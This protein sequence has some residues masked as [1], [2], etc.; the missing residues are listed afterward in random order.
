[1]ETSVLALSMVTP[2]LLL[3]WYFHSRDAYPE[4]GRV[5]WTTFGL[6]VFTV[7]PVLAF[8]MP[9]GDALGSFTDPYAAGAFEAF[10]LASIPEETCKLAVLLLYARRHSAF[11]EPMD[12]LVYG[13]AASLGFAT[14]ENILYVAQGGLGVALLRALTSVPGHATFGAIMGY[15]VG[16]AHFRPRDRGRLL[17]LAWLVPVLLHGFYDFPLLASPAAAAASGEATAFALLILVPLILGAAIYSAVRMARGLRAIQ[18]REGP[19]APLL[20][21]PLPVAGAAAVAGPRGSR[22]W[23]LA[24]LLGG[25]MASVGGLLTFAVATQWWSGSFVEHELGGVLLGTV[26]IGVAPLIIGALLFRVGVRRLNR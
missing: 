23:W 19:P 20:A 17:L 26:I 16:Q 14:F 3:L 6:G 8:A 10:V 18:L 13:V 9:V 22:I 11:D 4:P 25:A 24:V 12:G 2:S 5:V 15:F 1:M 7:V 21:A